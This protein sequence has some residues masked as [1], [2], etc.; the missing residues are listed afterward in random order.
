MGAAAQ[1][2]FNP[3]A[4]FQ[5]IHS[6]AENNQ[7]QVVKFFISLGISPDTK[8]GRGADV[9]SYA[10]SSGWSE[11]RADLIR[12]FDKDGSF[13]R[14]SKECIS[15]DG[16][17]VAEVTMRGNTQPTPVFI[18]FLP[19]DHE[20]AQRAVVSLGAMGDMTPEE[21]SNWLSPHNEDA[22]TK[23]GFIV[24]FYQLMGSEVLMDS[25]N[26]DYFIK[27]KRVGKQLKI[28]IRTDQEKNFPN[29][30]EPK[31]PDAVCKFVS[32]R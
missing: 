32:L 11:K 19:Q 12:I 3:S 13:E 24:G 5:P 8:D 26:T 27:F 20:T 23:E 1:L 14:A 10:V 2:G 25:W 18:R 22:Q 9:F 7:P 4:E 21:I 30:D 31:I 6:A 17:Y 28:S 29:D 16:Y 15:T